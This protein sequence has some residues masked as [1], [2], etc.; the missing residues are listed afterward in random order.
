MYSESSYLTELTIESTSIELLTL[1]GCME[2]LVY[3]KTGK[4]SILGL[5]DI[6]EWEVTC[7]WRWGG[8]GGGGRRVEDGSLTSQNIKRHNEEA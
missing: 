8:G 3:W 6:I 4:L 7:R 2:C 1:D 5:A